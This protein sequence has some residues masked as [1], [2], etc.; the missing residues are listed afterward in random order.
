MLDLDLGDL[1]AA[2]SAKTELPV[3]AYD[4]I[5]HTRCPECCAKSN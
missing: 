1:T 3:L 5:V 2:F 4:L